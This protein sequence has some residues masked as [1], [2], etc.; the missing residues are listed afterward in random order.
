MSNHCQTCTQSKATIKIEE[1]LKTC[2]TTLTIQGWKEALRWAGALVQWLWEET[3]IPKVVGL[4]PGAV[5]WMD[6][7][8]ISQIN[9]KEAGVGPFF[10]KKVTL[11]RVS[12][13]I[14]KSIGIMRLISKWCPIYCFLLFQMANHEMSHIL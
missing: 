7:F 3:H 4:I 6:I 14:Q 10:F 1:F 13:S 11:R 2:L 9:E 8:H 5:Y 12:M